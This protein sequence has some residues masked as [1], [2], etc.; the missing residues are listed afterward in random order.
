MTR[1]SSEKKRRPPLKKK[2]NARGVQA[3]VNHRRS[4][5]RKTEA[6]L[7]MRSKGR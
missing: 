7:V 2:E 4:V 3:A 6:L 1:F 5:K